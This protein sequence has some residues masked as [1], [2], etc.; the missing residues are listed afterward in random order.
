MLGMIAL[1]LAK[2]SEED[3]E[4]MALLMESLA[5]YWRTGNPDDE[6]LAAMYEEMLFSKKLKGTPDGSAS[7]PGDDA[8]G[9]EP[10]AA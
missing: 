6:A 10:P 2:A 4:V 9:T 1:G 3:V 8:G 5:R 7:Q